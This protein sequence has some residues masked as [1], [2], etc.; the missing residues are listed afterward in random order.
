MNDGQDLAHEGKFARV[1]KNAWQVLLS[2]GDDFLDWL[3]D[4][5]HII[6]HEKDLFLGTLLFLLGLLN[7]HSGKYCDGNTADYLSCTR[8]VTYYYYSWLEVVLVI[9]G[10]FMIMLWFLRRERK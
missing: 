8:P 4:R 1:R 9:F 6:I 7:F 2:T 5:L 10:V 3:A